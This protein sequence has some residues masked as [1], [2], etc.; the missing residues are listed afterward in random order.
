M[1]I[2]FSFFRF[3]S[4]LFFRKLAKI[5]GIV[6]VAGDTGRNLGNRESCLGILVPS[7]LRLHPIPHVESYI[8]TTHPKVEPK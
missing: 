4:F 3:S 2:L 1:E 6:C 5:P 8:V 7:Y